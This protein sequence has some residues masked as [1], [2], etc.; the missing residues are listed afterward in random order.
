MLSKTRL[1]ILLCLLTLAGCCTPT[2]VPGPAQFLPSP[3]PTS[4][5]T[6]D[7]EPLPPQGKITESAFLSYVESVRLAGADCR[8]TLAN[9][10]R[11]VETGVTP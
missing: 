2:E 8:S 3:I 1:S 4:L 5:R 11:S 9:A 6:C 7:S 10:V